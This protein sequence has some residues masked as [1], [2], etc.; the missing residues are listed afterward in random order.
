MTPLIGYRANR[1][2]DEQGTLLP[3]RP[4]AAIAGMPSDLD[5]CDTSAR[6]SRVADYAYR[7]A[8]VTAGLVLLATVM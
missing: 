5:G 8:A 1:K 3:V 4:P 7:I 6:P 2:L